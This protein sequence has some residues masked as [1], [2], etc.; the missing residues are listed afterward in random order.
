MWMHSKCVHVGD[1]QCQFSC[2]ELPGATNPVGLPKPQVQ[3]SRIV[4]LAFNCLFLLALYN[5][6]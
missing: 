5:Q 1:L 6:T 4:S 3:I 2:Q